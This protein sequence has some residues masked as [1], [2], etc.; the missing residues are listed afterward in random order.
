[1][2]WSAH[3]SN[4]WCLIPEPS[5]QKEGSFHTKEIVTNKIPSRLLCIE[6]KLVFAKGRWLGVG[7]ELKQVKGTKMHELP[8]LKSI[9]Q[10]GEK[11]SLGNLVNKTNNMVW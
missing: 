11:H 2:N 3:S 1:M 5:I 6:D 4:E 9:N 10:G 7:G 8:M